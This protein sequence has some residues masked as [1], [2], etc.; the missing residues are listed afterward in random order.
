MSEKFTVDSKTTYYASDSDRAEVFYGGPYNSIEEAL[1]R[2]PNDLGLTA[3][4]AVYI[5][6]S[7]AFWPHIDAWSVLEQLECD[8]HEHCGE[9]SAQW[10]PSSEPTPALDELSSAL[11]AVLEQWMEKRKLTPT[12]AGVKNVKRYDIGKITESEA[13]AKLNEGGVK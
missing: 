3:P 13:I 9:V 12:I 5:G 4:C 1:R 7:D 11:D 2:A 6:E 10:R 8:A